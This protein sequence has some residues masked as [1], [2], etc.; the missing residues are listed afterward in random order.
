VRCSYCSIKIGEESISK[1][2]FFLKVRRKKR[3]LCSDCY[4]YLKE[5]DMRARGMRF[6][7]HGAKTK[8]NYN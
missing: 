1:E 2:P 7:K 3:M 4:D 8:R 6:I 5:L